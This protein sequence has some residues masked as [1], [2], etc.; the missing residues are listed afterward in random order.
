MA[1]ITEQR[2]EIAQMK[3]VGAMGGLAFWIFY[4]FG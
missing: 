2:K 1:H 4:D 3:A